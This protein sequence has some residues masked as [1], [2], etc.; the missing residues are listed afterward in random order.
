MDTL[1]R[2]RI[3]L[4]IL[5]FVMIA[6]VIGY[7]VIE[8]WSFMD[9]L[10]MT[11]ITI[12]TVGFGEVRSLST[13]G[14]FFTISIIIVGVGVVLY[15]FATALEFMV[16]GHLTGL[17]GRR[18]MDKKITALNKHYILCGYGRVGQQV[19]REFRAAKATF[20]IIE[21]NP[22]KVLIC[23][24]NG[25]LYVEG[26]ASS[27]DV[28]EQAGIRKARGLVAAVDTDAGNVFV[29]LTARV[30]NP[31]MLIVAR[32]NSEES[33]EKLLKAGATRVISPT[34]IGGRRMA[35]LLLKP[36]V[37]DYLDVVS[38]GGNLE[39]QL[40]EI[41][42]DPDSALANRSIRKTQLRKK[43]G[44]L[45]LA[46]QNKTGQLDTNPTP[47]TILNPG[48]RIVVIGTKSQLDS[49]QSLL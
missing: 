30:L 32:A 21:N 19:A 6:G 27:D 40:E 46:V 43:V 16:E 11:V 31:A 8:R 10:Y 3:S 24:E 49:L 34:A 47:E 7:I 18:K 35:N 26:D 14:R 45:I 37:C 9:S 36:L 15:T 1:R 38:H 17:M 29:T 44:V 20:I 23:K 5:L 25:F 42:I 33:E 28:L 4:L 48:D 39:F 13:T 22:E 2:L 41:I 12:F